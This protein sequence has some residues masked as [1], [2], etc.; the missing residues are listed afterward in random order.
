MSAGNTIEA[1]GGAPAGAAAPTSAAPVH[2]AG[3]RFAWKR[4]EPDLLVIE[5][6]TVERGERVFIEGASGSGKSTLLGL[7]GGVLLPACGSVSLL[8]TDL[9]RLSA[10]ARDRFRADHVGFVFQVFNLLPY[11]SMLDNVTLACRF[12]VRRSEQV[13]GRGAAVEDEALRLLDSL[14]LASPAL[15]RR[16]VAELSIGQQ[17]RVALA[18]ALMGAPEVMICD[19]PTSALD[20]GARDRFLSLLFAEC[21]RAASTLLFVS[22]DAALGDRFDRRLR[23]HELAGA[24][25][26]A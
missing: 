22:H 1:R 8:G 2:I 20:A 5:E 17:Q 19:E 13:R 21:E 24:G 3:L 4:G 16:P 10:R 26:A 9:V 11:L 14:Q 25:A 6:L 18:R 7:L 23:M 15:L 12:S